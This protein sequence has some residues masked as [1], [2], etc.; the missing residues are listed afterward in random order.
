MWQRYKIERRKERYFELRKSFLAR[1]TRGAEGC[2]TRRENRWEEVI[3]LMLDYRGQDNTF[4]F[5]TQPLLGFY[6]MF[7]HRKC[8]GKVV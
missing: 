3:R 2:L 1:G 8:E 7:F 6:S 4:E 5:L